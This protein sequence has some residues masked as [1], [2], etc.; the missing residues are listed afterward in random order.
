MKKI[1]T[2][3]LIVFVVLT[4]LLGQ[5]YAIEAKEL[6]TRGLVRLNKDGAERPPHY[7]YIYPYSTYSNIPSIRSIGNGIGNGA[8]EKKH[9]LELPKYSDLTQTLREINV[10]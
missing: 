6:Q 1:G 3:L 5:S 7:H 9:I 4:I 10:D 2:I 8:K